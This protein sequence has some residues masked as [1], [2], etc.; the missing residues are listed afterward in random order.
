LDL[1]LW[2]RPRYR[3]RPRPRRIPKI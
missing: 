3:P 2:N 1:D